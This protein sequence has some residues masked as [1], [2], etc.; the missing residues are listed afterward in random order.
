MTVK[1]LLDFVLY[2]AIAIVVVPAALWALWYT[3]PS[4]EVRDTWIPYVMN[5]GLIFGF[6]IYFHRRLLRHAAFW[7]L[8]FGLLLVHTFLFL[9]VLRIVGYWQTVWWMAGV[10]P[11]LILLHL[12]IGFFGFAEGRRPKRRKG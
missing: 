5:T 7:A 1:R 3:G 11:E 9:A 12:A 10:L 8:I 2:V 6:T 4:E